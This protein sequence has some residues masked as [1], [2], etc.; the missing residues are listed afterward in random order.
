MNY[1]PHKLIMVLAPRDIVW[2]RKHR[3]EVFFPHESTFMTNDS[4]KRDGTSGGL[5]IM[6]CFL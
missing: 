3:K 2:E 6:V 4:G 1:V 5:K